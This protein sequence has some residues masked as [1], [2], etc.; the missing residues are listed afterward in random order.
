MR[1]SE[2]I[3]AIDARVRNSKTVDYSIWA[4]GITNDPDRRRG[5]HG[6]P[7]YWMSWKGDT[8][9]IARNVESHFIEKGMKGG[10]GGGE[11][12]THVY[13]F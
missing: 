7:E 6:E 4:I 9:T 1:E 8:E 3:G 5:E 2:I 12:P 11:R 13:I 10:T